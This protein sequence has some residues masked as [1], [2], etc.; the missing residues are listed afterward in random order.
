[1]RLGQRRGYTTTLGMTWCA[2][3]GFA[4][5]AMVGLQVATGAILHTRYVSGSGVWCSL[6]TLMRELDV[7][8]LVRRTHAGGAT[9]L[10]LCLTLHL[11]IGAWYGGGDTL[12]Q[13]WV[14][15]WVLY[16]L[17]VGASFTGYSLTGGQMSH[18]AVT[19]ICS[20][21][22]ATPVVGPRLL[23]L[24]WGGAVV[25]SVS[26][27]RLL[28]AHMLIPLGMLALVGVH[29]LTLHESNS[30]W[31]VSS[32][33]SDRV[34]FNGYYVTRDLGML[35]GTLVLLGV[36]VGWYSHMTMDCENEQVANSM[37]T[38][39]TIAPEWYLLPY[40]G[41]VRAVPAKV[42]GVAAMGLSYGCLQCVGDGGSSVSRVSV[43][44][45]WAVRVGL[46]C[47]LVDLVCVS[48]VCM[49]VN[50]G[51]TSYWLLV[52]GV[53]GWFSGTLSF[54]LNFCG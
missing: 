14:S 37:V 22:S 8:S 43:G 54:I 1:M 16:L 42:L 19:V 50:H 48:I 20:L 29:L 53:L 13:V 52:A 44:G 9:L 7:A 17:A 11:C 39:P 35:V 21:A 45:L 33:G 40:Y 12:R 41:L 38:P 25:T 49:E 28:T 10:M 34:G 5:G 47:V 6:A 26:S 31:G 15:G 18:W 23:E 32:P 30:V 2:S 36:L 46:L 51:E 27:M 3:V 4:L 24:L